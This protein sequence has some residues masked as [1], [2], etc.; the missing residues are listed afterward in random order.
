MRRMPLRA[1]SVPCPDFSGKLT[2][3][4]QS[5]FDTLCAIGTVTVRELSYYTGVSVGIIRTLADKGAAEIFE[6]ER[7]RR[8]KQEMADIRLPQT[9]SAEQMNVANDILRE[10][11]AGRTDGRSALRCDGLR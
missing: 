8:P 3:K 10:C 6:V 9:L 11:D 2:P 1:W 7:F 5:A 4:Q